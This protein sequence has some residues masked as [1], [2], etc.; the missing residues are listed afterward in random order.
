MVEV[1][2]CRYVTKYVR[3]TMFA[4]IL[5]CLA[6]EFRCE[7]TQ[8]RKEWSTAFSFSVDEKSGVC[9]KASPL[10][11]HKSRLSSRSIR[12][13]KSGDSVCL[14]GKVCS[15]VNSGCIPPQRSTLPHALHDGP[16]RDHPRT[17]QLL[18]ILDISPTHTHSLSLFHSSL[19]SNLPLPVSLD[20]C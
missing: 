13:P 12:P 19:E 9:S 11:L 15:R 6:C 7:N 8:K 5:C 1:G 2:A 3:L 20:H 14:F 10:G 16:A 4:Q 18:Q 17:H